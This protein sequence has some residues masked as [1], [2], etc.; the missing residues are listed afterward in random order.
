MRGIERGGGW[1]FQCFDLEQMRGT[2]VV[3]APLTIVPLFFILPMREAAGS[4]WM[5]RVLR[6]VISQFFL[7][8]HLKA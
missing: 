1:G 2:E 5:D 3:R 8:P 7:G 6:V 4:M